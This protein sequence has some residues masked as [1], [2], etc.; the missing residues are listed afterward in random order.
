MA[1]RKTV[2]LEDFT[3]AAKLLEEKE[4]REMLKRVYE[5]MAR[6]RRIGGMR[7]R[8]YGWYRWGR[9]YRW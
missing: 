4:H 9:W 8:W 2:E 1:G 6:V 3:L 7:Y 5:R